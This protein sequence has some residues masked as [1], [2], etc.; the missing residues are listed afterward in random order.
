MPSQDLAEGRGLERL[1][2]EYPSAQR[3]HSQRIDYHP[4]S[5]PLHRIKTDDMLP[6]RL[7]TPFQAENDHHIKDTYNYVTVQVRWCALRGAHMD[8]TVWARR[9][10][11]A[12]ALPTPALLLTAPSYRPLP[13]HR[14]GGRPTSVCPSATCASWRTPTSTS[15]GRRPSSRRCRRE[16]GAPL[17]LEWGATRLE[18]CGKLHIMSILLPLRCCRKTPVL[19]V[20]APC[21]PANPKTRTAGC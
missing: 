10:L 13:S 18:S 2:L 15:V 7:L 6:V 19:A 5:A 12:H 17:S 4:H 14:P 9:C 8:S 21:R 1:A 16:K 3:P 20:L 11:V